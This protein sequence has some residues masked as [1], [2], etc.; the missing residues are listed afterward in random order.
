MKTTNWLGSVIKKH[1]QK[2][3]YDVLHKVKELGILMK[4]IVGAFVKQPSS[5]TST[6]WLIDIKQ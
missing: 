4:K 3:V 6:R 5:N 1:T 2:E